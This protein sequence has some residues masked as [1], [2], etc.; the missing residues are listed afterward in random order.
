MIKLNILSDIT[1]Y[2]LLYMDISR[3]VL[4]LLVISDND[5]RKLNHVLKTN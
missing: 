2:V 3:N 5:P 1:K 4:L